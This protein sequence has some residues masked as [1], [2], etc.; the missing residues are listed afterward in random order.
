MVNIYIWGGIYMRT[1]ITFENNYKVIGSL[2]GSK[3]S[4][5]I[6]EYKNLNGSKN[7]GS[8]TMLYFMKEANIKLK[9]IKINLNNGA[10]KLEAGALS[11]L[12]GSIEMEN[13]AGGLL[14][15]GKK[16]LTSKLTGETVFK[17]TY[18]GTGEI[19]LEPSFGFYALI[20][21]Q[22]ESIIVDDGLFYAC[23]DTIEVG[24]EMQK[25][26]SS[27]L[28][29]NE[30]LFQ[31]K[32]SGTGIVVL[33]IPVPENEIVK[34]TLNNDV[35]KVDGNFALLRSKGIEFTV[36]KSSKSL[37]ASATSG[38]GL[39]NVF[40][41]TGE[42]WLAPTQYIYNRLAFTGLAGMTNPGGSSNTKA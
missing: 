32:I 8:A 12:R 4:F 15:L 31:T 14:G 18:K 21:L 41:G 27:T 11:F 1:N 16:M 5:E 3:S 35:L 10:V 22:N 6:L 26:L 7:V 34:Y 23:E 24:A 36:E 30:G 33:E 38:E 29:G 39:L 17:P 37:I 19:Y 2:E 13:K 25:N 42:V 40:R 9:Q 20:E 28:L